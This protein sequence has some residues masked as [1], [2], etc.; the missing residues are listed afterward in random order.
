MKRLKYWL[1]V[2]LLLLVVLLSAG[3]SLWN[4]QPVPLSFG[5]VSL[6][7]KP[8]SLW[9]VSSFAVGG[10]CGLLLGAGFMR[11]YRLRKRIRKLE[12][13]LANTRLGQTRKEHDRSDAQSVKE[14]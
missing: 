13:E 7:P 10:V 5:I 6:D 9:V 8:V 12:K 11:D 4:T 1:L 3:F 2:I 14:A